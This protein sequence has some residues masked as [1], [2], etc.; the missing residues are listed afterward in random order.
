[1]KK[2]KVTLKKMKLFTISSIR[3]NEWMR[4]R[5]AVKQKNYNSLTE[6]STGS[7]DVK[8]LNRT[9][10]FCKIRSWKTS[11]KTKCW[12]FQL[13]DCNRSCKSKM[14]CLSSSSLIKTNR[15]MLLLLLIVKKLALARLKRLN[16][17]QIHLLLLSN[18]QWKQLIFLRCKLFKK[19]PET[20]SKL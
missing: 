10:T 2:T 7:Q 3:S 20:D 11:G 8:R 4:N 15:K 6:L 13:T 17:H 5:F 1:M 9:R 19:H 14:K 12:K 18:K 16:K